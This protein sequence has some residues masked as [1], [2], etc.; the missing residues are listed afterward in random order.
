MKPLIEN[1]LSFCVMQKIN[2]YEQHQGV[3]YVRFFLLHHY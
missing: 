3:R 1:P 2:D